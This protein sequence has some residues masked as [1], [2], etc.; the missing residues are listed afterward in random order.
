MYQ[1]KKMMYQ[2]KK[3]MYQFKK[4]TCRFKKTTHQFKKMTYQFKK[5]MYQF[6]K[7]KYNFFLMTYQL[8]KLHTN[9]IIDI[10]RTYELKF[11]WTLVWTTAWSWSPDLHLNSADAPSGEFWDITHAKSEKLPNF[12][13][14]NLFIW[15]WP[16][17]LSLILGLYIIYHYSTIL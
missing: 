6:F 2:F 1:F 10:R 13:T 11:P 9:Q 16:W 7:K 4:M 14:T 15:V 17:S 3:M 8:K 12:E 5:M